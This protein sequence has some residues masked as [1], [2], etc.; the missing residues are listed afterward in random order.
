[1]TF[2]IIARFTWHDNGWNSCVCRDPKN[3]TYCGGPYSFPADLVARERQFDWEQPLPDKRTY[4]T[5]GR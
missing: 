2:Y 5:V 4:A 1:M 3:N